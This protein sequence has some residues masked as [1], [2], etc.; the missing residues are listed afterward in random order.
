MSKSVIRDEE[1]YLKFIRKDNR[2]RRTRV[3]SCHADVPLKKRNTGFKRNTLLSRSSSAKKELV[4][5]NNTSNKKQRTING[6]NTKRP[7][8]S[9]KQ[10]ESAKRVSELLEE[11]KKKISTKEPKVK[12]KRCYNQQIENCRAAIDNCIDFLVKMNKG[13]SPHETKKEYPI[14]PSIKYYKPLQNKLKIFRHLENS[15]LKSEIA[16]PS[17]NENSTIQ[18][19]TLPYYHRL[20]HHK[21]DAES[22]SNYDKTIDNKKFTIKYV[23]NTKITKYRMQETTYGRY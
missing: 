17:S 18:D 22:G 2:D 3:L 12:P 21:S 4:R 15:Q 13:R 7:D 23:Y 5:P 6:H 20:T 1:Y 16:G 19:C 14:T 11:R 8:N 9:K 10:K